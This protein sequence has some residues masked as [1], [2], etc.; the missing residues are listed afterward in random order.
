MIG[1]RG[2]LRTHDLLVLAGLLGAAAVALTAWVA[3]SGVPLPGDL[4][5]THR[6]QDARALDRNAGLINGLAG[7]RWLALAAVVALFVLGRTV[8]WHRVHRSKLRAEALFASAATVVLLYGDILLKELVRSPR[9]VA[10]LGVRID[11]FQ[12]SYGFPSGHVYG[13]VLVFGAAAVYA[14]LWLPRRLVIPVRVVCFAVIVLAGPARVAVGAHWPSDTIG[15]YL[16][17]AF[18]LCL[19]IVFGRWATSRA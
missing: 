3:Y 4:W 10:E 18:A 12:Q 15:G 8:T 2:H 9:P 5:L 11:E 17:G 16:W 14:R 19:A 13:D 1:S 7:W 6:V